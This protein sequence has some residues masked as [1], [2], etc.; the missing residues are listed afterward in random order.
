[1]SDDTKHTDEPRDPELLPPREVMSL[2]SPTSGTGG[3]LGLGGLPGTSGG[4]PTDPTSAPT[5]GT[6]PAGGG[7]VAPDTTGLTGQAE[8]LAS[9]Q[10]GS[11]HPLSSDQPQTTST[12]DAQ[13]ASSE[14]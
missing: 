7:G 9:A 6:A 13:S 12:S 8:Q 4:V 1:M 10:H 5:D 2:L 14:T 11:S 3:L